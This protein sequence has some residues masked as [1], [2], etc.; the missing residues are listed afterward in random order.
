MLTLMLLRILDIGWRR[1][2]T[3]KNWCGQI[4]CASNRRMGQFSSKRGAPQRADSAGVCVCVLY[5][6]GRAIVMN[7]IPAARSPLRLV[8]PIEPPFKTRYLLVPDL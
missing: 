7:L 4:S 2:V 6:F 1:Q 5:P 3:Y 8:R